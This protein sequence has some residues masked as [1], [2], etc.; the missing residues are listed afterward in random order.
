MQEPVHPGDTS[1][2]PAVRPRRKRRPGLGH[3]SVRTVSSSR[4]WTG[5]AAPSPTS[6]RSRGV[7]EVGCAR[8][9]LDLGVDSSTATGD[10]TA[11]VLSGFV[12]WSDGAAVAPRARAS[13]RTIRS[14]S[15]SLLPL[16]R[17]PER[18]EHRT[19]LGDRGRKFFPPGPVRAVGCYVAREF[20]NRWR[21]VIPNA[22]RGCCVS[23]GKHG[24]N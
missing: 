6:Q 5:S 12:G 3:D 16:S 18:L 23:G 7:E 22:R 11:D 2:P 17:R 21:V 14:G 10:A 4:S 15:S 19:R 1:A 8:L 9:V 20:R 13:G 24:E